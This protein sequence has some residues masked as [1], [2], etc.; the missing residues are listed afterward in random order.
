MF[1]IAC[2]NAVPCSSG[3]EPLN[4]SSRAP[5]V[6]VIRNPRRAYSAW[7]SATSGGLMTRARRSISRGALPT[8]MRASSASVSGVASSAA[9]TVWSSVNSPA[10]SAS[11]SAGRLRSASLARTMRCAVR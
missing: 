1:Q 2:S 5:P 8:A 11:S 10:P 3:S 7:S 4:L 9:A 6:Q